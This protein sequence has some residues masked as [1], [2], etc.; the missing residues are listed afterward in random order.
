MAVSLFSSWFCGAALAALYLAAG[1]KL[2]SAAYLG[3]FLL[4]TLAGSSALRLWIW[5]RGPA[6]FTAL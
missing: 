5:K 4:L 2:G 6:I 1:W 3:L